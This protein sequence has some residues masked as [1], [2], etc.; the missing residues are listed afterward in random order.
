MKV[1]PLQGGGG[2]GGAVPPHKRLMGICCWMGSHFH[3]WIDYNGVTYFNRVTR[4]GLYIFLVFR[5]RQFFTFT[6]SKRTRMCL[7]QMKSKV[8][9]IES[10]KWVSS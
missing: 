2:G 7:L 4:M 3:R 8:F 1:T 9:F 5:V 10:K 6:V